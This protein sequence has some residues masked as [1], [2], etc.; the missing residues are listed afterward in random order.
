MTTTE[1]NPQHSPQHNPQHSPQHSQPDW[2]S[3]VLAW[4]GTDAAERFCRQLASRDSDIEGAEILSTAFLAVSNRAQPLHLPLSSG[5]QVKTQE[6]WTLELG[7]TQL[8]FARKTLGRHKQHDRQLHD[9]LR[10]QGPIRIDRGAGCTRPVNDPADIAFGGGMWDI[11]LELHAHL[12]TTT[13]RTQSEALSAAITLC[14]LIVN[15]GDSSNPD[16]D[17]S[18][19]E[20]Q[21]QHD[22]RAAVFAARPALYCESPLP[23]ATRQAIRQIMNRARIILRD[24]F[25]TQ[26]VR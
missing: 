4:F 2:T 11:Y 1:H 22:V 18:N 26:E 19:F 23:A 13:S 8:S 20:Q 25:A 24:A 5:H 15:E 6:Q 9:R 7:R 17:P 3:Q 12:A 10:D 21:W 14:T 16:V